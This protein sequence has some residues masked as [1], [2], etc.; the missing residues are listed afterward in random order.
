MTRTKNRVYIVT[1][2]QHPSE[3][4]LE[5]IKDYPNVSLYGNVV[6]EQETN[7]GKIKKC[8]VCG[9]PLQ[10]RWKKNYGLKLWMCTNEPEICNFIT[11]DL[12]GG[13]MSVEK[14]DKCKDGYLIVKK[15]KNEL[16]LG[17]T[18]Y[19][20]DKTGCDRMMS[21]DY[22]L[23]WKTEGFEDDVSVDKPS[24]IRQTEPQM[25]S[26]INGKNKEPAVERKKADVHKVEHIEHFIEKDGFSVVVDNDGMLITDMGLLHYLRELRAK[27][28]KKEA[29]PAYAIIKNNGLVSLATYRPATKEEFTSLYGLGEI[30][31]NKY[32]QLFITAIKEYSKIK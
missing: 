13:D 3:F 29:V 14:C 16:I 12:N 2:E 31:Y 6:K 11:N 10:M 28:A 23:R 18:N 22:Y 4:I 8:P 9:Y 32:G 17:C 21:H 7:I 20:P 25:P 27:T 19:K 1:P 5:L 24:Y 30:A 15:G 26:I